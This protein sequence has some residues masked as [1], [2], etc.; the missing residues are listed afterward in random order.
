M[1]I[2]KQ[3]PIQEILEA[4]GDKKKI[5]IIGCGECS[6]TCQTGGEPEVKRMSEDL[7]KAGKEVLGYIIPDAPCVASQV[8]TEI[9][10]IRPKLKDADCI[11]VMACGLGV[12]SVLDNARFSGLIV[13]SSDTLFGGATTAA[14][15]FF[16]Y[17]SLCGDCVLNFTGGICPMTRCSKGLLNGPCG[18]AKDGKCE[19]DR[20]RDCAWILIYNRLKDLGQ[21]DKMKIS[22]PIKDYSKITKPRNRSLKPIPEVENKK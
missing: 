10:K 13:A 11:L 4:I 15:D 9:S 5:F 3:K 20:N 1:I 16:E 7:T 12:Q 22:R 18:G 14:N 8:K 19:V 21:I 6:T 2:T 17:C